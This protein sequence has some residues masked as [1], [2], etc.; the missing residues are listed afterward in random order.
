MTTP[1]L[2]VFFNAAGR[3]LRAV[4]EML[5]RRR[6]GLAQSLSPVPVA[7]LP[8]YALPLDEDLH[9]E[10]FRRADKGE[11]AWIFY[12][13]RRDKVET[14]FSFRGDVCLVEKRVLHRAWRGPG[15]RFRQLALPPEPLAKGVSVNLPIAEFVKGGNWKDAFDKL[16]TFF[17]LLLAAFPLDARGCLPPNMVDALPRNAVIN[18]SGALQFFDLEYERKSGVPLSFLIYRA[19]RMDMLFRLPKTQR[20]NIAFRK[21]YGEMCRRLG[22]A[23]RFSADAHESKALKR[24]TS[25]SPWRLPL[26]IVFAVFPRSLRRRLAWWD[27]TPILAR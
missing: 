2:Y 17:R 12:P 25:S 26:K 24:F 23:P 27:A 4:S 18:E 9:A 3:P 19:L 15:C 20:R 5:L 10:L 21:E 11:V 16:E 7:E 1:A 13:T 22:V 14:V 6:P 8:R